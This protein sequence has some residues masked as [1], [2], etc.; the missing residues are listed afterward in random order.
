MS[1]LLCSGLIMVASLG[2]EPMTFQL[3]GRSAS[4]SA[5]KSNDWKQKNKDSIKVAAAVHPEVIDNTEH[6]VYNKRHQAGF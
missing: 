2:F 6:D 4:H 5:F 3:W 1:A